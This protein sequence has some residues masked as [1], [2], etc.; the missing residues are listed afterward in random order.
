MLNNNHEEAE[1]TYL[2]C[3]RKNPQSLPASYKLGRLYEKQEKYTEA[4]EQFQLCIALDNKCPSSY[5]QIAMILAK[6]PMKLE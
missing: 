5:L 2:E 6:E 1:T 4:I 3:L